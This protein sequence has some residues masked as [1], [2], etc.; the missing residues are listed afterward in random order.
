M[1]PIRKLL[2]ANR[3]EIARRVF[4]T[5]RDMGIATVAVCSDPDRDAPFVHEADEVVPLGGASPAES[6]LRGE[7]VVAAARRVGADAVHPG[8][9]FLSENAGFVR[10]C[11]EAGLVFV[12][13]PADAVEAMGS[14][15][16]AKAIMQSAGVPVLPSSDVTG[17]DDPDQLVAAAEAVGWPV[18]VKASYGGGGRGMRIVRDA[19]AL[20]EAVAGARREAASAF[21]ND[22]VFLERYVEAPRHVEI[23]IFGDRH[24]N[25]VHL[26]ER[27]CSIQ[28]RHQKVVEEAPSVAVDERLRAEMGAA[29]VAAGKAIGYVGAGTV[30][31]LL[32]SGGEFFFLEVNT[33]LQVE[34]PVTESVTGLDLVRLQLLVAQ[35]EPLPDEVTAAAISGHAIEVRLYAEDAEQGWRPTTGT[36]HRFSAPEVRGLRVD[37]GVEAGSVVSVNYDPMLAK[38]IVHAR[39]REEAAQRL[40]AA[41]AGMRLHGVTTNRDFL[42]GVLRHPEFLAGRTDTHFLER[43]DPAAL[44][45]SAR[46]P[47]VDALHALAAAIALAAARR[48]AAPVLAGLPSGWRNNASQLHRASFETPGGRIEV[49]YRL[50]RDTVVEVGGERVDIEVV[51]VSPE[52]VELAVDGVR[53]RY[54]VDVVGDTAYVDSPLGSTVLTVV[55]RLPQPGAHVTPGSLLAPMPGTV[56]RVPAEVGAPVQAGATLVVI[57]A[58]K[59]EHSIASPATGVVGE[60][61]VQVGQVVDTG[62]VLVVVEEQEEK[63]ADG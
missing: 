43:H 30:E 19:S 1:A 32:T 5:C 56:V 14:K 54:D 62:E 18:L 34:H 55:D 28:R 2:V 61:R 38:V 42:V 48:A 39:T 58:M 16:G 47:D 4:R 20:T 3:A 51:S 26:F 8:Y 25:V 27:E 15:L 46:A 45:R 9:G 37:S 22:T 29:A 52:R 60:V 13:P 33:R 57:E 7:A 53:R 23:Q 6:Y 11:E 31:F 59:M 50:G 40:A 17:I 41:L 10:L 21:G 35:G 24:G 12:G 49:A 44:A 63:G 36:F